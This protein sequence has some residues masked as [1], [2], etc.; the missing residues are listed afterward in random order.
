MLNHT[1]TI[2]IRRRRRYSPRTR[3]EVL[4]SVFMALLCAAFIASFAGCDMSDPGA[5]IRGIPSAQSCAPAELQGGIWST[6]WSDSTG[7]HHETF[8]MRDDGSLTV[9]YVTIDNGGTTTRILEQGKWVTES[10]SIVRMTIAGTTS[11][12]TYALTLCAQ[13]SDNVLVIDGVTY[14]AGL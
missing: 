2:T 9:D 6:S 3:T 13:Q 4:M 11:D 8:N 12:W 10:D 14:W 7:W 1:T 5:P